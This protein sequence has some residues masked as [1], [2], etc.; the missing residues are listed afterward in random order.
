MRPSRR[1]RLRPRYHRAQLIDLNVDDVVLLRCSE[2][3]VQNTLLGP[4]AGVCGL[5]RTQIECTPGAHLASPPHYQ[6]YLAN[7]PS[8]PMGIP[9]RFRS[10]TSAWWKGPGRSL[11]AARKTAETT[12]RYFFGSLGA[13]LGEAFCGPAML[14]GNHNLAKTAKLRIRA[15]T[16][17]DFSWMARPRGFE[18]LT[19]ASGGQRS[20]QLSYG[21]MEGI[22]PDFSGRGV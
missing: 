13:K 17:S 5:V 15:Q 8:G 9:T 21:R 10:G 14:S 6:I 18:P 12:T 7:W 19:S 3:P 1:G 22:L 11:S 4:A 2:N 20:I 16:W